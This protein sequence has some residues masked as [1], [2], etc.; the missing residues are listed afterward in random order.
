[1]NQAQRKF[2]IDRIEANVKAQIDALNHSDTE[3][4]PSLEN[5]FYGLALS[6]KLEIQPQEH[7][8]KV[9]SDRAMKHTAQRYSE[10]WLGTSQGDLI[11]RASVKIPIRDLFVVPKEYDD[12]CEY[13]KTWVPELAS[14][15]PK[16][17]HN[18]ETEWMN[19]KDIKYPKPICN[20]EEQR[21]KVSKIQ[22]PLQLAFA[23]SFHKAQGSTLE[24]VIIDIG[25]DV[26]EFG[27]TYVAL[28]R[29][30]SLE[31]LFISGSVDYTKILANPRVLKYY[32]K[33]STK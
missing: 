27:Q 30:K 14:L 17:I 29:V 4:P 31:G 22:I 6:G 19:Y 15:E 28:S 13:I 23:I 21:D 18:W 2:L 3:Q 1:M 20:Y 9:M 11:N 7:I 26:F 5:Y 33:L 32:E 8:K 10:T 24:Y 12:L 16:I 25:R